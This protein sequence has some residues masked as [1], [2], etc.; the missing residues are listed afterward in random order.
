MPVDYLC[1]PLTPLEMTLL[2]PKGL[3]ASIVN[4]VLKEHAPV[5]LITSVQQY[6]HYKDT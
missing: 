5:D 6:Q 3:C 2:D 4:K 1:P